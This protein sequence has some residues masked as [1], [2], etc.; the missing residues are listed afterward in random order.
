VQMTAAAISNARQ[1]TRSR[2]LITDL[3]NKN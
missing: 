3:L 1:D 2:H